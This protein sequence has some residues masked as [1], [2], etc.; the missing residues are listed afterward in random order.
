M[1]TM[2][3]INIIL[4]LIAGFYI[5]LLA[6]KCGLKFE[7]AVKPFTGLAKFVANL[8]KEKEKEDSNEEPSTRKENN[9][10]KEKNG[11]RAKPIL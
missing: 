6:T 9:A 5:G 7:T 11:N 2:I 8:F 4:L 10:K 3:D 1:I